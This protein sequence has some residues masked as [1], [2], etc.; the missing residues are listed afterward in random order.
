[1]CIRDRGSERLGW[2]VYGLLNGGLALRLVAEPANSVAPGGGWG[3]V[4]VMS[5][6][7]Q[8][9]AAVGFVVNSWPRV[10]ERYRGE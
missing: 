10:R 8:W 1:M 9:L 5:A 3:W 6:V 2:A 4:L 7:L